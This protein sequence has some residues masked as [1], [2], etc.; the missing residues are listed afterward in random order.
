MLWIKTSKTDFE[1]VGG[2]RNGVLETAGKKKSEKVLLV[3]T[4][5]P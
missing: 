4:D 2:K 5:F 3:H 1:E